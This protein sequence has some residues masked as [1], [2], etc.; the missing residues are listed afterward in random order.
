MKS[1]QI[2]RHARELLIADRVEYVCIAI[3]H[4]RDTLVAQIT[5]PVKCSIIRL[6]AMDLILEVRRRI[7]P[8]ALVSTWVEH[9]VKPPVEELTDERLK[10]YRIDWVTSMIEEYESIGD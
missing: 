6:K 9:N 5:S 7:H 8:H 3:S 10:Q 2:L 1:S 4:V